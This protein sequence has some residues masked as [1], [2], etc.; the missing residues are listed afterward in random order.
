MEQENT[1]TPEDIARIRR[2]ADDDRFDILSFVR[3]DL[4]NL[5]IAYE[6]LLAEHEVLKKVSRLGD[7]PQH[8]S[9]SAIP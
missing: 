1:M 7:I 4:L 9:T 2:Y 5:C 6:K 3:S 8:W